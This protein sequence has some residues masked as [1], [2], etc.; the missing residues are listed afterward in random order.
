MNSMQNTCKLV[1]DEPGFSLKNSLLKFV[2]KPE[3][4]KQYKEDLSHISGIWFQYGD[5]SLLNASFR[6]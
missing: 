1:S 4:L 3:D 6:D 2:V 5:I